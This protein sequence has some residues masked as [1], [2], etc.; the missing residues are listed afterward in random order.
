MACLKLTGLQLNKLVADHIWD[1][2]CKSAVS[3]ENRTRVVCSFIMP[4][5]RCLLIV[6]DTI[7]SQPGLGC[8][9]ASFKP[10]PASQGLSRKQQIFL[11]LKRHRAVQL[12]RVCWNNTIQQLLFRIKKTISFML[13]LHDELHGSVYWWVFIQNID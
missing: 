8:N 11:F 7:L 10:D 6:W 13:L 2:P 5:K 1:S 9:W 4:L 12:K 3:N